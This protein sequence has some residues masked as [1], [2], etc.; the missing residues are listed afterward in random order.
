VTRGA[1]PPTTDA[2]LPARDPDSP[3]PG[4]SEIRAAAQRIALVAHR[5]PVMTCQTLDDLVGAAL[6]FKCENLQKVGAFKFRG[7]ANAV[8][9][10]PDDVA[11]RGV[12]THSSGNHAQALALAARLRGVP[13]HVV[14][15]TG[16]PAVKQAAVAGYGATIYACA[17]TLVA[18]EERLAEVVAATGA[19]FVHPYDDPRVI[20]GQGTAALELLEDVPDLEVVM[21]P[22]GGGGL[23][24]GTAVAAKALRSE[25]SVVAAEP[26]GADDAARSLAAGRIIPSRDPSTICDGLLTSLG[27]HNFPII[28]RHVAAILTVSD[29]ATVR[30]MRWI[31][32]R[33]KLVVEPSAAIVLGALLERRD[34]LPGRRIGLIL[35]G[36]NADLDRLPW[37][38]A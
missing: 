7:A 19:H 36:G 16:A 28:R 4:L 37:R 3:P 10:L 25:I 13:A 27:E 24:A 21:T 9:S 2:G 5:T 35:S 18:R 6:F 32:E 26:T 38:V 29:D 34:D 17:P 33:M 1:D 30:A 23:L 20:A 11:R 8:F 31:W 15:P 12:A 22:V 14:M